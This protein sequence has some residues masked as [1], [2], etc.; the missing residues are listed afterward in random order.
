M[1]PLYIKVITLA[2]SF[3]NM[4]SIN[5]DLIQLLKKLG[6]NSYEAKIYAALVLLGSSTAGEV[7]KLALV[8]ET[9]AYRVLDSLVEK[10]WVN[11]VHG[12]PAVYHAVN[13]ELIKGRIIHEI[14]N[15][16]K[17]LKEMYQK[18]AKKEKPEII[19]TIHGKERV[20]SKIK[21]VLSKAKSFVFI[22]SPSESLKEVLQHVKPDKV[23]LRIITDEPIPEL[24]DIDYR[25]SQPLFAVDILVDHSQALIAM[26][27]LSVCGWASNPL[28]AKHFGQFLE[29]KWERAASLGS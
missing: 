27:D 29:L 8:P 24:K 9:S 3:L 26:P 5:T 4:T 18:A 6:L 16:F 1:S 23:T 19:Y 17:K 21:E 7:A 11:V 10:G 13:P 22:S 2:N 28:I 20:L 12:R 15:G 25:I 14:E